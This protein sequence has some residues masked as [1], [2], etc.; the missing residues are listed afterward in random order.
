MHKKKRGQSIL[1]WLTVERLAVILGV[2]GIL[3]LL[4]GHLDRLGHLDLY[5]LW[6]ELYG[7]LGT[8]LV[9]IA[10]TV[11]LIDRLSRLREQRAEMERLIREMSSR[12]NATAIRAVDSLRDRGALADGLL[13]GADLK[14]ANLDGAILA[15][16][17][18][19]RA[20]LSF[21]KLAGA[22]LR[23]A[24]LE[25]AI[26]RA[27][28]LAEAM[29][30]NARL[31]GVK[32]L[33]ANLQSANLHGASL[34]GANLAGADLNGVRGLSDERLAEAESLLRAIMPSG[35]RYDGRFNLTADMKD[36]DSADVKSMAAHYDVSAAAYRRGQEW[37]KNKSLSVLTRG[38]DTDETS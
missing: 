6:L 33:D 5:Q 4:A 8:G 19:K 9:D 29:L 3:V 28:D 10:I 1:D 18:L 24:D 12:D 16:A 21:G 31:D 37:A 35:A 22:D 11:L 26:L 7:N 30:I 2:L 27:A 36:L 15:G 32:L 20:Y 38:K 25:G 13:E 14:Y 34:R 23:N 17:D